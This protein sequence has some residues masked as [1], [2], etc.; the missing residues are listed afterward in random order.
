MISKEMTLSTFFVGYP[1]RL[2]CEFLTGE[3]IQPTSSDKLAP[4]AQKIF[5]AKDKSWQPTFQHHNFELQ[6]NKN[7]IGDNEPTQ[8]YWYFD[9]PFTLNVSGGLLLTF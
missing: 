6:K 3:G 8:K 1:R 7:K 5:T 9:I 2:D 4:T